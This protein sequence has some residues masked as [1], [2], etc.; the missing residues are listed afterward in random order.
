MKSGL[1]IG[2]VGER[3]YHYLV[4][5]GPTPATDLERISGPEVE[6]AI[7]RLRDVGLV[8][9]EPP[10]ARHPDYALKPL[11]A[12][13]EAS[14]TRLRTQAT[15]LRDLYDS[16]TAATRGPNAPVEV[17]TS[18]Q[19]IGE[20]LDDLT[21]GAHR[22]V[23]HFVT[24]PFAPLTV[25]HAPGDPARR[26]PDGTVRRPRRRFIYEKAVLQNE[27]AM[28]GLHNVVAL[29][30]DVRVVAKD[31]PF[32]LVISDRERALVPRFPRGFSDQVSSLLIRGGAL[33]EC[34]LV[35]FEHY[36]S[37]ATP[38]E[39]DYNGFGPAA[40][41]AI[42]EQDMAILQHIIAGQT[43][44]SMARLMGTSKSTIL[45]RVKRMR[46]LAGVDTR[47]ALIF[48]AARNWMS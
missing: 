45:R 42:D 40:A 17:L 10:T 34:M 3:L 19:R 9:G 8:V 26:N 7:T 25:L 4:E 38:L 11:V 23:L 13:A 5:H 20:T 33:V 29:G 46:E 28:A 41:S 31:L 47:P 30:A 44:D 32:K 6:D 14:L 22:E 15:E 48:H 43:D 2:E 35:V 12:T 21:L 18:R 24:A 1:G 36:W 27:A 39:A 16:K 37:E